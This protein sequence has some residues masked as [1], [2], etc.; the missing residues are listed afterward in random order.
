MSLAISSQISAP[1]IRTAL[2]VDDHADVCAMLVDQLRRAGLDASGV[3]SASELTARLGGAHPDL[4]VLD[5][6]LGETD[7]IM[8]FDLL[9]AAGFR[10]RTILTSGY[11]QTI[12]DHA[13]LIGERAGLDIAGVLRK[14]FRQRDLHALLGEG[15]AAASRPDGRRP[16]SEPGLL[17]EALDRGWISFVY[18]PK[19][20]LA[21]GRVAGFECLAR[22][23]HPERGLLSPATFIDA[24][25]GVALD[26]LT[27]H[28]LADAMSCAEAATRAGAPVAVAV[29][30]AGRSLM[31]ETLPD[32]LLELRR[33]HA[34]APPVTLE[35][36][37]TD[38]VDDD[39][40][41]QEFA[42][43]AALHGFRLSIDDFGTGFAT[44][45]RLRRMP[46]HEIKLERSIVAG[47]SADARQV[48]ICRASIDIARGFGAIAVAEGVEDP[49][50]LET[51]RAIGFDV[52]QGYIFA[53]PAAF[54]DALR[55]A[56]DH[57]HRFAALARGAWPRAVNPSTTRLP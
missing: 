27:I 4:I 14:P 8:A 30:V 37:E 6:A 7:A 16:R 39:A 3:V 40:A 15:G 11:Q 54:P 10:G 20:A 24:A 47:C 17:E 35:L 56:H 23:R 46:F 36:T 1:L 48:S 31:N 49:A 29:N 5:L 32:R 22:I 13:R 55:F 41:V 38:R 53:R 19:V 12:L 44:F 51:V 52:A 50:D 28:A 9:A 25:E 33:R 57:A 2:V 42:T 26:R 43:R 21:D 34:A 18:Q 45:D